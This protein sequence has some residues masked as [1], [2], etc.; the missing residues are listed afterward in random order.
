[1]SFQ[2]CFFSF[3]PFHHMRRLLFKMV[4]MYSFLGLASYELDYYD[5][6]VYVVVSFKEFER[7]AQQIPMPF[8]I[9][10][11]MYTYIDTRYIN[12]ITLPAY[13][14]SCHDL[15]TGLKKLA[16]KPANALFC[17]YLASTY[18]HAISIYCSQLRST[19]QHI[20]LLTP[21]YCQCQCTL[22]NIFFTIPKE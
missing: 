3:L 13:F 17:I 16:K 7:H 20:C 15:F 4:Y 18:Q 8:Q 14:V 19:Y 2:K 6:V 11:F 21:I 5:V 1:M 22:H 12:N 10:F 9:Q